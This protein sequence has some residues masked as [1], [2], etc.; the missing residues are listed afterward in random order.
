MGVNWGCFYGNMTLQD[1]INMFK[2]H[3]YMFVLNWCYCRLHRLYI[4]CKSQEVFSSIS[5]AEVF[6]IMG[7]INIILSFNIVLKAYLGVNVQV[8]FCLLFFVMLFWRSKAFFFKVVHG[9]I[10]EFLFSFNVLQLSDGIENLGPLRLELTLCLF[11]AWITVFF[12]LFKGIKTSGK[13]SPFPL[14]EIPFYVERE[15]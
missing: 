15:G 14:V 1:C 11:V 13:V 5:T 9:V 3:L 4:W 2:G 7:L 6:L 8:S 12:C 10:L